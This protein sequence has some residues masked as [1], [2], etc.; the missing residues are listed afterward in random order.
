MKRFT[1]KQKD[2]LVQGYLQSEIPCTEYCKQHDLHP[3]TL[4]RWKK[5]YETKPG[6]QGLSSPARIFRFYPARIVRLSGIWERISSSEPG[7]MNN[8]G[9]N[10]I[11]RPGLPGRPIFPAATKIVE[12]CYQNC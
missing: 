5:Q 9:S 8:Q 10:K 4:Y 2:D 7:S 3:N 12:S 11:G 1:Q 6:E